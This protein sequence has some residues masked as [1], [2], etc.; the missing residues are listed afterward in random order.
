MLTKCLPRRRTQGRMERCAFRV[1]Q[2]RRQ[3]HAVR[4]AGDQS[5]GTSQTHPTLTDPRRV[6]T[7]SSETSCA[8]AP[9]FAFPPASTSLGAGPSRD[10]GMSQGAIRYRLGSRAALRSFDN[11]LPFADRVRRSD[12]PVDECSVV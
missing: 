12:M 2:R 4:K 9:A 6:T 3:H 11:P 1:A 7:S 5:V 10:N 8:E